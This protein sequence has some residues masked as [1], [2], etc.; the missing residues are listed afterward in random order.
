MHVLRGPAEAPAFSPPLA[1]V[2]ISKNL[3]NMAIGPDSVSLIM[4]TIE[5]VLLGLFTSLFAA[6]MYIMVFLPDGSQ[7]L[8]KTIIAV[9]ISMYI[10]AFVHMCLNTRR[11]YLAFILGKDETPYKFLALSTD[12]F[13]LAKEGLY[14]AQ[15]TI[16]DGFL[17]YRLY[18]VW[19]REK[20]LLP[21]L[22]IFLM[23][24]S[25]PW[26]HSLTS[27]LVA[28]GIAALVYAGR[29]S[30]STPIF[31]TAIKHW[32]VSFF[33]LTLFTNVLCTALISFK[34]WWSER[35]L[36]SFAHFS[37]NF[38]PV[39]IIVIESGAVYSAALFA[40][41]GTY[42][43]GTWAYYFVLD[44]MPQIIGIVF[45]LIIVRMGLKLSSSE[46][47]QHGR[48][49]FNKGRA[50]G[51]SRQS[52]AQRNVPM[53]PLVV[54][55]NQSKSIQDDSGKSIRRASVEDSSTLTMEGIGPD[56]KRSGR[57]SFDV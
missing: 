17:I 25:V 49:P 23:G 2:V 31:A 24:S 56:D 22:L 12:G 13:Y 21:L 46:N 44:S 35:Q 55:I 53:Q 32:I 41:L 11:A 16:G 14:V 9:S 45:S 18:I 47:S 3:Y 6:T 20:R 1:H 29:V 30:P 36:A 15:T 33:S 54:K 26:I 19:A 38:K 42:I 51:S 34:I 39:M 40:L 48:L 43:S 57:G 37:N 50:T 52:E 5:G 7:R 8:N 28:C 10:V 4:L 27:L